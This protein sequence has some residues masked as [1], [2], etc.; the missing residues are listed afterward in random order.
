MRVTPNLQIL[1]IVPVKTDADLSRDPDIVFGSENYL[2]VWSDGTFG[3]PHKVQAARVT[4][5]GTVLDPFTGSGS[6]GKAALLNGY[7]FIGCELTADY[8]P[9]IEGR[10]KH[11]AEQYAQKATEK[12]I[13]ETEALF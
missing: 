3:G 12:E 10:L 11:A 6:T 4:P 8:L 5:G 2:V 1:N 9:I 7:K 13:K